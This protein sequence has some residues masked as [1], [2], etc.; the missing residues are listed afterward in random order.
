M[1]KAE[2]PDTDQILAQWLFGQA[3]DRSGDDR[4]NILLR[5]WRLITRFLLLDGC[6]QFELIG[7]IRLLAAESSHEKGK[8]DGEANL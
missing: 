3:L 7:H 5:L 2:A 6:G 8:S 1:A 4:T